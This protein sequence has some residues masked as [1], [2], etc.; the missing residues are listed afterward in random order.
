MVWSAGK[1]AHDEDADGNDAEDSDIRNAKRQ[2]AS[3]EDRDAVGGGLRVTLLLDVTRDGDAL[4]D[5]ALDLKPLQ[6]SLQAF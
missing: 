1:R 2:R 3:G 6:V 5:L 4:G